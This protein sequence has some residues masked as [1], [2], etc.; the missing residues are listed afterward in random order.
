MRKLVGVFKVDIPDLRQFS[1][2]DYVHVV[3][4]LSAVEEL[5]FGS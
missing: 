2:L 1:I 3:G 5:L 4:L